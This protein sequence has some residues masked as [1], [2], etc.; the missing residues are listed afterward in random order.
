MNKKTVKKITTLPVVYGNI[1]VWF[2]EVIMRAY[3]KK[4]NIKKK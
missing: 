2:F 4:T 1:P 3:Y